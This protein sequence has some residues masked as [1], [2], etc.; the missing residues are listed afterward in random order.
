TYPD[1]PSYPNPAWA[2]FLLRK[3]LENESFKSD[4][5]NRF[6][7]QLNTALK[8]EITS[9]KIIKLK[10]LL[11]PEMPEHIM[12]WKS[13]GSLAWWDSHVNVLLAYSFARPGHQREHIR[14]YFQLG[15]DVLLKV[16]VSDTTHGY[17][18]VNDLPL[19]AET[20]GI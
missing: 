6:T 10:Q 2:T 8:P 19:H 9:Q 11:A 17:V 3:L 4:F 13:P 15:N 1:G 20:P 18:K 14:K 5:I 16:N 7:G 12:R